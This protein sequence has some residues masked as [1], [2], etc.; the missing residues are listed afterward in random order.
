MIYSY[1]DTNWNVSTSANSV[2]GN[3]VIMCIEWNGSQWLAGAHSGSCALAYSGDGINW[4]A[5]ASAN[6]LF[7]SRV[8]SVIWDG[9]AWLA[10]GSSSGFLAVLAYSVDGISW[11]AL[12]V[13]TSYINIMIHKLGYNGSVYIC[14]SNNIVAVSQGGF[15]NWASVTTGSITSSSPSFL[16]WTGKQWISGTQNVTSL[17]TSP[18]GITW[19]INATATTAANGGVIYSGD[20]NDSVIVVGTSGGGSNPIITSTDGGTTWAVSSASAKSV[21]STNAVVRVKWNGTFFIAG[22]NN[23]IIGR[24][25]DGI[26][27]T[28]YTT[29][30]T[31]LGTSIFNV[32]S[33]RNF[34]RNYKTLSLLSDRSPVTS[35]FTIAVGTGTNVLAYSLDGKIW[36]PIVAV[37][38]LFTICYCVV[39]NGFEWLVGG[40]GSNVIA[41]SS[42]GFTWV[43]NTAN[44]IFTSVRCLMWDGKQWFAGG[45]GTTNQ[46]ANSFDGLNWT[47]NLSAVNRLGGSTCTSIIFNGNL[48]YAFSDGNVSA[49][50]FDGII[51]YA[52]T[53]FAVFNPN[54]A[55]Y[56][57]N[58]MASASNSG[59]NWFL[60]SNGTL[61]TSMDGTKW[62]A[63]TNA[64]SIFTCFAVAT[65]NVT[66]VVSQ[67]S[68]AN[69]TNSII[70]SYDGV[71]YTGS[72]SSVTVFG[73][74]VQISSLAWNGSVLI[75]GNTGGVLGW[76]LDGNIW[77]KTL[78]PFTGQ[79]HGICSRDIKIFPTNS[80]S[81]QFTV[82]VANTSGTNP[83]IVYSYDG[84][85][86]NG[87]AS[88]NTLFSGGSVKCVEWNGMYWLAG[89][90]L[91]GVGYSID[92]RIWTTL[93]STG[94]SSVNCL[95]WDGTRWLAGG[96]AS[97]TAALVYSINGRNWTSIP[98]LGIG[99]ATTYIAYNGSVY[100]LFGQGG[101]LYSNG[102]YTSWASISGTG[103]SVTSAVWIGTMWIACAM[104]EQ[105]VR[106]S[107]DGIT[108]TGLTPANTWFPLGAS[109][110]AWNGFVIVIAGLNNGLQ[111]STLIYSINNAVS[112][113][114]CSGPGY[115]TLGGGSQGSG[116]LS[117]IWNGKI[118][119]VGSITGGVAYSADAI[120]WYPAGRATTLLSTSQL[121]LIRNRAPIKTYTSTAI[122]PITTLFTIAVCGAGASNRMISSYDG[123]NWV[124]VPSINSLFTACY[125][126]AWNDSIWLVGGDA[127]KIA[128]SSD[129]TTWKLANT[130][131]TTQ[132]NAFLWDTKKWLAAGQG[133][134]A[135][136]YSFNG[137]VWFPIRGLVSLIG[138][139][140][141]SLAFNGSMYILGAPSGANS[142]NSYDGFTWTIIN[143]TIG[144]TVGGIAWGANM[145][146]LAG[147]G[148]GQAIATSLDGITWTNNAGP[149]SLFAGQGVLWNGSIF[150]ANSG[151]VGGNSNT[152]FTSPDGVTWT[153][154]TNG[155]A[156]FGSASVGCRSVGWNGKYF[157]GG[158]SSGKIAY[159]IDGSTWT[160]TLAPTSGGV[161]HGIAS[162]YVI[163]KLPPPQSP[164]L[165]E[166]FMLGFSGSKLIYSYDGTSW[167]TIK[168][169]AITTSFATIKCIAWNGYM[170]LA[171]G[172]SPGLVGTTAY[173][174]NSFLWYSGG[175]PSTFGANS[176]INGCVWDMNRWVVCG[177][178]ANSS[179]VAIGYSYDG[180][181]NWVSTS[182]ASFPGGIISITD[183]AWNGYMY[184]V[185]GTAGIGTSTSYASTDLNT[186]TAGLLK[187][188][189]TAFNNNGAYSIVW[190]EDKFVV[191]GYDTLIFSSPDGILW[192]ANTRPAGMNNLIGAKMVYSGTHFLVGDTAL[193]YYAYST[194]GVTFTPKSSPLFAVHS[195]AG[196][197][198]SLYFLSGTIP[199]YTSGA[200][201]YSSDLL[202]WT[203]AYNPLGL[204]PQF[205][206]RKYVT[207]L[208]FTTFRAGSI[209]PVSSIAYDI[210]SATSTFK[211]IYINSTLITGSFI[212]SSNSLYNLG[213][214]GQIW[215][216]LFISSISILSSIITVDSRGYFNFRSSIT[217]SGHLIPSTT[218]IYDLGASNAIW[219]TLYISS[220]NMLSSI[221]S[222]DNRGNFNFSSSINT[223]SITTSTIRSMFEFTSSITASSIT[224]AIMTVSSLRVSTITVS[225]I[226]VSSIN[227]STIITSLFTT[228]SINASTIISGNILPTT[229]IFSLGSSAQRWS[230]ISV[231]TINMS[232]S[233]NIMTNS[234]GNF[235]FSGA[236]I[237]AASNL[238]L[239]LPTM[240]WGTLYVSASTIDIAGASISTDASGKL[241]F[242]DVGGANSAI[243]QT[244]PTG[245]TGRT[246]F[247]GQT[248]A[249]GNTGPLGTGPTG[250]TGRTGATGNTGP[251]G[252]GPTGYTGQ[253]G[254]TGYTGE[255]GVN[256]V[257]SG[258]VF[259]LDIG[260]TSQ[261]AP[262][263]T[264]ILNTIPISGTQITLTSPNQHGIT[265]YILGKFMTP[266]GSLTST[267]IVPGL[268]DF[269]FYAA[270]TAGN[271]LGIIFYCNIYEYAADGT[272]LIGTISLGDSLQ[273][274]P[275]GVQNLYTYATYVNSY[276]LQSL[277]SRIQVQ[278]LAD[279]SS[280]PNKTLILELRDN[281]QS[282]IHTTLIANLP[283]GPT[284]STGYTG[285]T[286]STGHT[287]PI[288]TGPTGLR[289]FTGQTGYTG[290]KG[291][292]IYG[293]SGN[294]NYISSIGNRGDFYIDYLSGIMYINSS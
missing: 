142:A 56:L 252:T 161:V 245:Y 31:L 251:L 198:G 84:I 171:G 81:E 240:R 273:G 125:C 38:S 46:V 164:I 250:F 27:W 44:G 195:C 214:P 180:I 6:S 20:W 205:S 50:S 121:Y 82:M 291:T 288:G 216:T 204:A 89:S 106:Q 148:G 247:T 167:V 162:R 91:G 136:I 4:T 271:S 185:I 169:D 42:D 128:F 137:V 26:T 178:V 158:G 127:G 34:Q 202:N 255:A 196:Y 112:F 227:A 73:A 69:A 190:K 166:N 257:S 67:Y 206:R 275:I 244:G 28:T 215:S 272:T 16:L 154:S 263:N 224:S 213:R 258:L 254:S 201:A 58:P 62:T 236:L 186:W 64:N 14:Y 265:G 88:A 51:W 36:A 68:G 175:A 138:T 119:I 192:T 218:G 40:S 237:P 211:N 79:V 22:T 1:D 292:N 24:S 287:G 99:N 149:T 233:A 103:G 235:V 228:S 8:N 276:S 47:A 109:S 76:S 96:V 210:G 165:D 92:G 53:G 130:L 256:G 207:P 281:T 173:S 262:Y 123:I 85:E 242:N 150:I 200:I 12:T 209:I 11:T 66:L 147:G 266:A 113:L 152:I 223:S 222:V 261:I 61:Q 97:S 13:S 94:L 259:F 286:G 120:T 41:V 269:N 159:S 184:V 95:L 163:P 293:D 189:F 132:V 71:T 139:G 7:T 80:I 284:G 30:S 25:V 172:Q 37:N 191:S 10:G 285:R 151:G 18:D 115:T 277:S 145:W 101:A 279:F 110:I 267:V 87:S 105:G 83:L 124:A 290:P 249:T 122:T 282:H 65:T 234:A 241:A 194:D 238:S 102:D 116:G 268:W 118:F 248:G 203:L 153:N 2:F 140:A 52:G 126:V 232:P 157:I 29:P 168:S 226:G 141:T 77:V 243:N 253:R 280:G 230:S 170:W 98:V 32:I 182:T 146:V 179:T 45:T 86:W 183:M 117:A 294:P 49:Y 274:V 15:N 187:P 160:V 114:I 208:S 260:G 111:A 221:I 156:I 217:T 54:C 59:N 177:G 17:H 144:G 176:S 55:A 3:A 19:T 107:N 246:G 60:T 74:S 278:I 9:S 212:P 78:S 197:N 283:T 181:S 193:P 57:Q 104:A 48:Y 75:G 264:G 63:V 155:T 133:T 21:F 229:S 23:N 134:F 135:L 72:T 129:G 220:I 174:T 108:W 39:W 100:L 239:G 90:S 131:F 225:T 199:S 43:A 143:I 270:N 70:Y 93:Y 35:Q 188:G 33:N 289:G 231:S 219:S 5:S